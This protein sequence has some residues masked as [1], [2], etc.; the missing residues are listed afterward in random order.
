MTQEVQLWRGLGTFTEPPPV[1]GTPVDEP[2][3]GEDEQVR[4]WTTDRLRQLIR[5]LQPY[6]DGT[7]G[8]VSTKHATVYLSAI[9]ELNKL[10]DAYYRPPVELPPEPDPEV[11]EAARIEAAA[12]VRGRVLDQLQELRDR[13]RVNG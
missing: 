2:V 7:F 9:R 10:W 4:Y 8:T 13:S 12:L 1:D 5:N 3:V 11:V 6:T